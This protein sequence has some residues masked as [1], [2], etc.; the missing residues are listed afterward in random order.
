MS[1]HGLELFTLSLSVLRHA[2]DHPDEVEDGI[3]TCENPACH[4]RYPIVAGIPILL[5][6][7][8]HFASTQWLSLAEFSE[9]E[10]LCALV[11]DGPDDAALPRVLEYLSIYLD[12]HFGDFATP[13]PDGPEPGC[14][15]AEL[16]HALARAKDQKVARTIELG[17]G[18]GRGLYELAP[19]TEL[20]VGL[21][22]QF[23]ALLYARRVLSGKSVR[24]A[25]RK[26][27]RYYGSARLCVPP[28]GETAVQFVCGDALDP[29]FAP[30]SFDRVVSLNVLDSVSDAP[31]H[32]S[33]LDGLCLPGGELL[34]A[35]PFS[36]QTGIVAEDGRL[37]T[38][39]PAAYLRR[40]FE[41]GQGLAASYSI[42]TTRD[43]RWTLRR[44]ARSAAS[45]YSHYLV[46]QKHTEPSADPAA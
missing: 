30:G 3:L 23:A 39:D 4:R 1:A 36:W 13:V 18:P 28:C 46:A 42:K 29:P 21:D 27:G 9:P 8:T 22:L 26:S 45:Y 12:A 44:D 16:W 25:R 11:Q 35:S 32:L 14:G 17:C 15:G 19:G 2:P 24:Y 37:N 41:T 38:E 20:V 33:V 7:L 34:L 5:P 6:N 10:V 31:R 40:V 43:V